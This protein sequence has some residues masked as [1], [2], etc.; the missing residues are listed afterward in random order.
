MAAWILAGPMIA[1]STIAAH[2]HAT[3]REASPAPNATVKGAPGEIRIRFTKEIGEGSTIIVIGP[4]GRVDNGRPM[5]EPY[6][7]RI[8]LKP[9]VAGQY[10]VQWRA[11]SAD[12]HETDGSYTFTVSAP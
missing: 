12:G 3:V 2:A 6:V 4:K 8:G 10:K 7:M 5:V 9:M 11:M 1:G